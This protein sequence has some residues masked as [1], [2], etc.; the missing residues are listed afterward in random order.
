M[1]CTSPASGSRRRCSYVDAKAVQRGQ[2]AAGG[3]FEDRAIAVGPATGGCPVE[4]PVGGLHQPGVRVDAVASRLAE[5]VQ[6][7]QRAAGGDFEDR[8]QLVDMPL[9][10]P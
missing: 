7:G 1:A 2:R 4:V 6:R 9:A 3:D 8:A 5:A 10:P